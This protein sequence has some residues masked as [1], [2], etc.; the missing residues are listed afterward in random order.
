MTIKHF[1]L[2]C[3]SILIIGIGA[4]CAPQLQPPG[5]LMNTAPYFETDHFV[6]S[7]GVAL[8]MAV[9]LPDGE[10]HAIILALHG[11]NDYRMAFKDS[12]AY[13]ARRG[14]AVYAIDQRGFGES[15]HRGLWAGAPRMVEDTQQLADAL[16]ALWP[17]K[18]LYVLGESMGGAVALAALTSADSLAVDGAILV[19][20]AVWGRA[21]MNPF[22]VAT[23]SLFSHITPWLRLGN[24]GL[25]IM[26]SDNLEMLKELSKDPLLIRRS[27]VDALSGLTDL[28]D[29]A[30]ESGDAVDRPSLLLYGLNDEIIRPDSMRHF[31]ETLPPES[32][33]RLGLY[34]D[35]YHMLLRDQA[36]R[37]YQEDV[38]SWI[39]AQD[40]PLPSGADH[41]A[42][43]RLLTGPSNPF[44]DGQAAK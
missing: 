33:I 38:V 36:G 19:A 1:F 39:Y 5:P 2:T 10:P 14:L 4:A 43:Y 20:P 40:R 8:P 34:E 21:S 31:I 28:M 41:A 35:G 18:P 24:S 9:W 11:F 23:L 32:P 6:A 27:R 16:S 17:G 12:G 29:I 30:L 13:F 25:N 22:Q 37:R 15:P 42:R 7:D 3:Q 44:I 26:P